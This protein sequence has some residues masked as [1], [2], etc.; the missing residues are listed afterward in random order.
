MGSEK[1]VEKKLKVRWACPNCGAGANKHGRGKTDVCD[2]SLTCSGLICECDGD[3]AN[4]HG[5]TFAD[6]CT[7]ANCY[8][9]GWGGT[10]PQ[11]PKN[12]TPWEERALKAG[13][14]PPAKRA[15]ELVS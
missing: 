8:H 13:W 11:K 1:M 5:T 15:K 10:L 6:P 12:V 2:R 3:V 7:E 9:C 4:D 14:T